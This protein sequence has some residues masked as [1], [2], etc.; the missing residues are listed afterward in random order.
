MVSEADP[1]AALPDETPRAHD[2]FLR[3]WRAG[4]ERTLAAVAEAIGHKHTRQ[5]QEWS[6]RFSWRARIMAQQA[7]EARQESRARSA[8]R[9]R[10]RK[11]LEDSDWELGT[12]LRERAEQ[13]IRE[14]PNFLRRD[15]RETEIDGQRVRIVTIALNA[16][17]DSV[18]RLAASASALQHQAVDAQ[19]V[20]EE[21]LEEALDRLREVLSP[22]DYAK[23]LAALAGADP[24][25]DSR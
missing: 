4:E 25:P 9:A 16:T 20:V 7:V 2:A 12:K 1:L 22:D 18:G 23:A 10:R 21:Q 15:E 11:E 6:G 3:Y 17:P 14:M 5:V 24:L 13:L 8:M 19:R